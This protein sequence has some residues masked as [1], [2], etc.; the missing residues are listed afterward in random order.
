[1]AHP[2][3]IQSAIDRYIKEI[4]R[5]SKVLDTHLEGRQYLVGGKCTYADLAF[6]PWQEIAFNV[7]KGVLHKKEFPNVE[8]WMER[9][10]ARPAVQEV[11][12]DGKVKKEEL[13]GKDH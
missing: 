13:Y 8:A 5:I 6:L 9:M 12:K 11:L 3:K 1:M 10:L 7:F 2:E 4:G